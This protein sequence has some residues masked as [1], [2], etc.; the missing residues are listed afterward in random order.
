MGA[1]AVAIGIQVGGSILQSNAQSAQ[2][3]YQKTLYDTNARLA[4]LQGED[5]IIRG[6]KSANQLKTQGKQLIGSQRAAL[7]AQGIDIGSGSALDVQTDTAAL[8]AEDAMTIKNNAWREAWG[9]KVAANDA[10]NRG[11]LVKLASDNESRNT[12]LTGG[13][14]AL[15]TGMKAYSGRTK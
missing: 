14:K 5:A 9:Y 1:T 7:A 10:T 13:L 8:I 4:T 3:N 12:L 15:D 2:G 11:N 6:D